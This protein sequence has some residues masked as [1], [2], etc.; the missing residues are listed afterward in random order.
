MAKCVVRGLSRKSML[1]KLS[2]TCITAERRTW[3]S[4]FKTLSPSSCMYYACANGTLVGRP[5]M[6][7]IH[8]IL[9][10]PLRYF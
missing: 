6:S 9:V 1:E 7:I 4:G 2:P 5:V 3:L 8:R 10:Q